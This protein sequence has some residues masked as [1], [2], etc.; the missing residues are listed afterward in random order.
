MNSDEARTFHLLY[1]A[2]HQP[3]T[4]HFLYSAVHQAYKQAPTV[5][6]PQ[7]CSRVLTAIMGGRAFSWRVIGITPAA[8]DKF[9]EADF[10]LESGQGIKRAHLRPPLD[11]ARKL[12]RPVKPV[13][14]GELFET[15][16][17]DDPT[18]L[19]AKGE[20]KH[21]KYIKIENEDGTLFSGKSVGWHHGEREREFLKELH[22][23]RACHSL[24]APPV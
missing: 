15:W 8:L 10:Y 22:L 4:F 2:V 9:A 23:G 1:S 3:D 24:V 7:Q 14:E 6:T 18:I 13:S 12:L 16:L 20:N 21:S 11:T 17:A 5:W 19:C